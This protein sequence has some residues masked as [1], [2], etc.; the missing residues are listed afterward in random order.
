MADTDTTLASWQRRGL[1]EGA[2]WAD[3]TRVCAGW[4]AL[5][6]AA[7]GLRIG[8]LPLQAPWATHLW[9]WDPSSA[10]IV[11]VR[12]D[13]LRVFAMVLV[14]DADAPAAQ[15][16]T[17]TL[18]PLVLWDK[19]RDKRSAS[20]PQSITERS[21]QSLTTV[22]ASPVTFIRPVPQPSRG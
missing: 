18:T 21:W 15:R 4:E 19:A 14:P 11:R 5:W 22:E 20:L 7:S 16:I 6:Q 1:V 13:G 10:S 2:T 3:L 12:L 9:A 8:A 17:T